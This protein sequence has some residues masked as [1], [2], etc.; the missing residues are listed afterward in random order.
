MTEQEKQIARVYA[1]TAEAI[2]DFYVQRLADDVNHGA[3]TAD[4]LRAFVNDNVE[5][6]VSPSS[7]DRI[8]RLLRQRGEV[9]YIVLNRGKSL[10][11][12]VP[13]GTT[14]KPAQNA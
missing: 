2:K 6:G 7:S 13:K 1:T 8:L 4:Q 5:N 11:R 12:A 3:F 9:D 14:T 10:Y